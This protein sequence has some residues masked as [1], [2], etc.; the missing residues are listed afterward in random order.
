MT[1]PTVAEF[2]AQFTRDFPYGTT[3]ETVNDSDIVSAQK[4]AAFNVYEGIF[5][6]EADYKFAYNYLSA[7]YLVMALKASTQGLNGSFPWL[8]NNKSVGSVSQGFTIPDDIAQRPVLAMFTKTYY[9]A[10]YLSLVLPLTY[11]RVVVSGGGTLP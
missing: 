11:G 10:F 3:P 9:G 7:H 2:K 8:E 1:P 5:S 6:S 4:A